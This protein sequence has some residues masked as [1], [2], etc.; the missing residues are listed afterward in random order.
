MGNYLFEE[1]KFWLVFHLVRSLGCSPFLYQSLYLSD[2]GP[3]IWL[4]LAVEGWRAGFESKPRPNICQHCLQRRR[5]EKK[6]DF[7]R[8]WESEMHLEMKDLRIW[9]ESQNEE[10]ENPKCILK[11]RIWEAEMHLK[12]NVVTC[13]DSDSASFMEKPIIKIQTIQ[14]LEYAIFLSSVCPLS[15]VT[16]NPDP[17]LF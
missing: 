15:S 14:L 12:M 10:S 7:W 3:N 8:I 1:A 13:A 9:N 6:I 11:W 2:I 17:L 16:K 5:D 4:I